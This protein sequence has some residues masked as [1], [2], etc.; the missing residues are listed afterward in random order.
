ML[1]ISFKERKPRH[2]S[3]YPGFTGEY[4]ERY[5]QKLM[6]SK[7]AYSKEIYERNI[8]GFPPAP[9][10]I[11]GDGRNGSLSRCPD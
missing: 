3:L 11:S 1:R 4:S 10:G 8:Y 7:K 9:S 5:I 2:G 6:R